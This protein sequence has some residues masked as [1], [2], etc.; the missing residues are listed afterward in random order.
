VRAKAEFLAK[1]ATKLRLSHPCRW[2]SGKDGKPRISEHRSPDYLLSSGIKTGRD[3]FQAVS[4]QIDSQLFLTMNGP[5]FVLSRS[6]INVEFFHV[7][8]VRNRRR[9]LCRFR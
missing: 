3:K 6:S 7:L 4:V 2:F 9:F 8:A 5:W 1:S